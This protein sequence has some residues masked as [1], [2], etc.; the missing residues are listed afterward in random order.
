MFAMPAR[1]GV[2]CISGVG[3][4]CYKTGRKLNLAHFRAFLGFQTEG[5]KASKEEDQ[6]L[7]NPL[8]QRHP[9]PIGCL[10]CRVIPMGL[11][12]RWLG[13]YGQITAVMARSGSRPWLDAS[14]YLG[15]QLPSWL[16]AQ[17]IDF[18][19]R[20]S[21]PR[22]FRVQRRVPLD[23]PF[24]EACRNGDVWQIRQHLCDGV[25]YLGDRA[26]CNGVTPLLV[27]HPSRTRD[28]TLRSHETG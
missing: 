22:L 12:L 20:I 21:I 16:W 3:L 5:G 6:S 4:M 17:S 9:A 8:G 7:R 25:G 23:S 13:F 14:V 2:F 11:I 10:R 27:T 15:Y 1:I 24:M 26:T 19:F 28:S 18:E